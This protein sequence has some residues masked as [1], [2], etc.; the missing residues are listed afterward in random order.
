MT[1]ISRLTCLLLLGLSTLTAR[2]PVH[3]NSPMVLYM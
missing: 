3:R 1:Y 2:E